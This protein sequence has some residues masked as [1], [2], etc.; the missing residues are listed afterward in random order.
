MKKSVIIL[1]FVVYVASVVIIGFY[2]VKMSSYNPTIYVS[3]IEILNPEVK[4]NSEGKKYI[5]LNFVEYDTTK[6]EDNPNRLTLDIKVLPE[7]TSTKFQIVDFVYDEDNHD[8]QVFEALRLI[9]FKQPT[10]VTITLV[11]RDG[12]N[13]REEITIFARE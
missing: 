2:G 5:I 8:I 7:N 4:Q 6:E 11:S 10:A 12:T 3:K 13:I 9:I 1:I